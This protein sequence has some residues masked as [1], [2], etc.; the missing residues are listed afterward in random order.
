MGFGTD[1][2]R[3]HRLRNLVSL[4]ED[5]V[6]GVRSRDVATDWYRQAAAA[7]NTAAKDRLK[8]LGLDK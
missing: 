2:R 3:R 7:G 5:E 6:G 8:R 4:W 1:R